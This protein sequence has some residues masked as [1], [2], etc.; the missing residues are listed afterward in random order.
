MGFG[1]HEEQHEEG[2]GLNGLTGEVHLGQFTNRDGETRYG[3]E[4]RFDGLSG[5]TGKDG[6][7]WLPDYGGVGVARGGVNVG[8]DGLYVGGSGSLFQAGYQDETSKLGGSFG[9]GMEYELRVPEADEG[10]YHEV[11]A[12]PV[13][14]GGVDQRSRPQPRR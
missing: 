3:A 4:T 7:G 6:N 10:V 2:W 9:L 5:H 8:S 12:G 1:A 13:T 11:S 14:I